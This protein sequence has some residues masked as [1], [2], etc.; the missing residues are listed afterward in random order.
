MLDVLKRMWAGRK[1]PET[2]GYS[3]LL[4]AGLEATASGDLPDTVHSA[5]V[6]TAAG[7][8]GRAFAGAE[9]SGPGAGAVTSEILGWVGRSLILSGEAVLFVSRARGI[10]L[11]PCVTSERLNPTQW[12]I[13]TAVPPGSQEQRTVSARRIASVRWAIDS[14]SPWEGLGPFGQ[15][16]TSA[17]LAAAA[18]TSL[19]REAGAPIAL[20]LPVPTGSKD[21]SDLARD[22]AGASGGAVMVESTSAGWDG[23]RR[24]GTRGDWDVSRVG[25]SIPSE[26]ID[27]YGAAFG[28]ALSLAGI[29]RSLAA[30]TGNADG[31]QLREDYRRFVLSAVRPMGRILTEKLASAGVDVSLG[32]YQ[33]WAHD[34]QGRA[35]A[36]AKLVDAGIPLSEAR[37][38]VGLE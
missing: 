27:A 9:V 12:R 11:L 15:S 25:P 26:L 10:R 33:L 35:A 8:W 36:L 7:I 37:K 31:T 16:P 5:A 3:D 13:N 14:A 2:R 24:T 22:I 17:R 19:R 32:W 29:P 6:Q 23:G 30:P 1:P 34:L 21:L 28:A 4:L 38:L 18:E 20:L